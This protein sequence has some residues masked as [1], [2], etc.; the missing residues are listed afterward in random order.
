MTPTR[1]IIGVVGCPGV[2]KSTFAARYAADIGDEAVVVPMDGFHLATS[3]L[4]HLARHERKGAPDTFD[5]DGYVHLLERL[6]APGSTVYAPEFRREWEE[7]VAAAIEVAPHHTVVVTEGN[8][9]LHDAGGWEQVRPLLDEC[10]YLDGDDHV[11]RQ[12]LVARHVRHGR[13]EAAAHRW[14][15]DVDE[16]NATLIRATRWRA[17]RVVTV[18]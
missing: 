5:I 9:L 8:Y 3:V 2:G 7:P 18:D 4:E 11:R 13:S 17:D 15:D 10:W 12:R 1:R 16:P 6:R 14:V